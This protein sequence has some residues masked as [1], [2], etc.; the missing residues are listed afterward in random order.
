MDPHRLTRPPRPTLLIVD[1]HADLR[2]AI[3]LLFEHEGYQIAEADNGADALTYIRSGQPV[4]G[5]VLDLM[6]PVMDG[7]EFLAN[8]RADPMWRQ[9]PTLVL[10][11]VSDDRIRAS[12]L[13]GVMVLKKPFA[14]DEL[15][16]AVR[17]M[18]VRLA[19]AAE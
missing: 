10:T 15:V 8:W 9:V 5:I 11:G 12:E 4:D 18:M 14:F 7:W 3:G 19:F 6:M 1:D 2:D 13:G 17:A 16:A